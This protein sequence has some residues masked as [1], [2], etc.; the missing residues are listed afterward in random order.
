MDIA[1]FIKNGMINAQAAGLMSFLIDGSRTMLV[2]W[3]QG[4][5]EEI[6]RCWALIMVECMKEYE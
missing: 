4:A 2:R 1:L 6:P 5:Q 3:G